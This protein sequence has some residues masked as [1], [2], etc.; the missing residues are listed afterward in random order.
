MG[1]GLAISVNGTQDAGLSAAASV[2]V[3]ERMGEMTTYSLRYPVDVHEG[4][5]PLLIDDRIA[6]GADLAIVADSA[7]TLECLVKGPVCGQQIRL[8]H[9]GAGS[10]CDVRGADSSVA[11]DREAKAVVWADVSD[12]NAVAAIVAE[13]GF[14]PD[15]D[16]TST[17]HVEAKHALVQ[18]DSDL[19]FVRRLARR[20]GWLFWMTCNPQGVETA[21]FKPLPIGARAAA[22]LT[23]NLA[24]PSVETVDI[25]WD[26]ERP[27]SAV[28]R[29]LDLNA[30]ADLDGSV[31]ASPLPA[32]AAVGL[33]SIVTDTRT[34]QVSAPVDAAGDLQKRSEAA[35]IDAGF[36]VRVTCRTTL[37]ALGAVLR[38]FTVVNLRGAGRRHSGRYFCA[39]VRHAIDAAEHRMELELLRNGWEA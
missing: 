4:D 12:S 18:R 37:H 25:A 17:T 14:V 35:L 39:G 2:E 31:T 13:Y 10:Y 23:I 38:P 9:G 30:A 33:A 27:T 34:V 19:R 22:D 21:H 7:G 5:L 20:N 1:P 15:V 16:S 28:A 3:H 11:M 29:E 36:F 26:V 6:P 24:S 32:M 8:V